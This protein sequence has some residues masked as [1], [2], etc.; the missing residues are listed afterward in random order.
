M[1]TVIGI[2]GYTHGVSA[3]RS[4]AVSANR[5]A[6]PAPRA[7]ASAKVSAWAGV[8]ASPSGRAAN[9]DMTAARAIGV[10]AIGVRGSADE[11]RI[12]EVYPTAPAGQ[13]P[14]SVFPGPNW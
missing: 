12:V 2:I 13:S 11:P 8:A 14:P 9:K 3:V 1:L 10:R 5:N 6:A 7:D 4:P